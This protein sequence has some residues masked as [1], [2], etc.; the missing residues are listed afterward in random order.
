MGG[1]TGTTT[2]SVQIPPEVLARYKAVNAQAQSVAATPFKQYSQNPNDFVAG[3]NQQQYAGIGGINQAANMAQPSIAYAQQGYTPEGFQKGVQGYMNPF[4][5]NA[6]GATA[7]QMQN[8]NQQQQQQMRGSA[9]GQ[10]AFG[11]DRAN[12]GLA[13]LANQQNLATGQTLANMASQGY[14]NAAQNY[15]TG[16]GQ[17][18]ALGLQGQQAA[19]QGAQAQL[20]AGTLEQQTQQA[21]QTALYNQFLQ[22]QAYPFQ[23]AQFLANIAMGTGSLS[24]S[25]TTTTQPMPFFSDRRL[26]HDIKRIGETDEG[27]PIYKFKYKG[28][29]EEQTHVGFMADEVEKIHPEAVGESHGYKTVDYDR[30]AKYTGGLVAEG[31]AVYPQHAGMGFAEGGDVAAGLNAINALQA[32]MPVMGGGIDEKVAAAA[33]ALAPEASVP[34]SVTDKPGYNPF[35]DPKY[36]PDFSGSNSQA[37]GSNSQEKES[38]DKK[39]NANRSPFS[40]SDR[41][42]TP[43]SFYANHD[44][45]PS[46]GYGGGIGGFLGGLFG[47]GDSGVGGQEGQAMYAHG[48]RTGYAV[49]GYVNDPYDPYIV[50]NILNRQMDMYNNLAAHNVPVARSLSGGI[51]KHSRVPESAVPVSQLKVA[52]SAPAIPESMLKQGLG[53]ATDFSDIMSKGKDLYKFYQGLKIDTPPTEDA[54]KKNEADGGRI[55]YSLGSSVPYEKDE[56][57]KLD[58]PN[59]K[60]K[61]TLITAANPTGATSQTG[62]SLGQA[63]ALPG[64]IAG[65]GSA[66]GLGSAG[67]AGA[68]GAAG[69][70]GSLLSSLGP[71][72]L[73]L[74]DGGVA[75]HR[76]HHDGSEGNVVGKDITDPSYSYR[77]IPVEERGSI[78]SKY[79]YGPYKFEP[80]PSESAGVHP[81]LIDAL[82]HGVT[83]ALPSGYSARF[84]SGHREVNPEHPNSMHSVSGPAKATDIE[85]IDPE[86]K[87]LPNYQDPRFFKPYHDVAKSTLDYLEKKDP[88]LAKRFAWGGLFS[89]PPGKYGA[90]DTMHYSFDEP[91]AGGTIK[92]GL[93]PEQEA[94]FKGYTPE[95]AK[96]A[97][98]AKAEP[99]TLD[100]LADMVGFTKANAQEIKDKNREGADSTDLLLSILS[101]VGSMASSNS[102]YLGA[103]ILQGLGGGAK[104]YAGLRSQALERGLAQQGVDISGKQ[105]DITARA[106]GIQALKYL[107]DRFKPRYDATGS[108]IIG[109]IDMNGGKVSIDQYNNIM[110]NAATELGLSPS[111]VPQAGG[112]NVT[113]ERPTAPTG[114]TTEAG[115]IGATA[116]TGEGR[117]E[118]KPTATQ[119]PASDKDQNVAVSGH[120][121]IPLSHLTDPDKIQE[122]INDLRAQ[123]GAAEPN[124]KPLIQSEI[125]RLENSLTKITDIASTP[126]VVYDAITGE[127][128]SIPGVDYIR[129]VKDAHLDPNGRAK[130]PDGTEVTTGLPQYAEANAKILGEHINKSAEYVNNWKTARNMLTSLAHIYQNAQAG[131]PAENWGLINGIMKFFGQE[132]FDPKGATA[133]DAA[134]KTA[135]NL[136]INRTSEFATGAPAAGLDASM[137]ASPDPK[138]DPDALYDIITKSIG[139]G[140]LNY[141]RSQQLL[142]NKPKDALRFISEFAEKPSNDPQLYIN[143]T[144]D[145]IG[146]F[147]GSTAAGAAVT[148]GRGPDSAIPV[149]ENTV[150]I[151]KGASAMRIN[152]IILSTPKSK[153]VDLGNGKFVQ[154]RGE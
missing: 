59:E 60:N 139:Y 93:N 132:P 2:Q 20:G 144:R 50:R 111:I 4:L 105:L 58:I 108:Q 54:T 31:G 87:A 14:Q 113:G 25:T 129:V 153:R 79:E 44:Y 49:D 51:S 6:M 13:N 15:M 16:M 10:G 134:M 131:P 92:G 65:L 96:T 64:Q 75:G 7:A 62:L 57:K 47:G 103:A 24:G 18:G 135:V 130:L 23:V 42:H 126:Q 12:I 124:T 101:G 89:G 106:Q 147:K 145:E 30:A 41:D 48:G 127:K 142:K 11:G 137:M 84:V 3:I 43:S 34:A 39:S 94:L 140:D 55:G 76:E 33:R 66:L 85:I 68:A 78:K 109:Y 146:P 81:D 72:A 69:G 107:Q 154:G 148:G 67:A 120:G 118:D 36:Q 73:F 37:K 121:V 100:K 53:A 19:L 141:D 80:K 40:G 115:G 150:A 28:D 114:T 104:T 29:P 8:I 86:G 35:A 82:Q 17:V 9:I 61:Y 152:E 63:L 77:D 74:K 99:S 117:T 52:S 119:P 71:L 98:A 116:N 95:S 88:E 143:R 110:Q 149:D 123:F 83:S 70:L 26:K 122:T 136:A 112:L 22:Q 90:M 1:K 27:L 128:R 56:D 138:K 151:P 38:E 125:T 46:T 91:M 21:G 102:P 97:S 32:K 133:Y 45:S 5:Q